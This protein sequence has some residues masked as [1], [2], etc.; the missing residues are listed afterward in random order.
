MFVDSRLAG[1]KLSSIVFCY[2]SVYAMIDDLWSNSQGP[3]IPVAEIPVSYERRVAQDWLSRYSWSLSSDAEFGGTLR[4]RKIRDDETEE[5]GGISWDR[6][7]LWNSQFLCTSLSGIGRYTEPSSHRCLCWCT[8]SST[9]FPDYLFWW[10]DEGVGLLLVLVTLPR[11]DMLWYSTTNPIF[12][13]DRSR[14]WGMFD[15]SSKAGNE[16]AVFNH[17]NSDFTCNLCNW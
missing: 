3:K 1:N 2:P 9:A 16:W 7:Q 10:F 17:V 5:A 13:Q 4:R 12:S 15:L 14:R 8:S 6:K 11:R